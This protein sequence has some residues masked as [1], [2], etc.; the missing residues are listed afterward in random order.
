MSL[1]TL[2]QE[3]IQLCAHGLLNFN[4]VHGGV[5]IQPGKAMN[6]EILTVYTRKLA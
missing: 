6:R 4:T 5:I 1:E 2:T 3:V